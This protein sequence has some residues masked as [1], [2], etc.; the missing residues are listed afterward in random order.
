MTAASVAVVTSGI[1]LELDA[2]LP[3]V[4]KALRAAGASAE[5]LIWDDPSV[6]WG[7][8]DLA[9]IRSTWDYSERLADFLSWTERAGR[10]TR[11]LNPAA[12]VRWNSDKHYLAELAARGVPTAPTRFAEPGGEFG[13]E[14]LPTGRGVVVKPA[15]SAGAVDT[16]RYEAGRAGDALRHVRMLTGQGRAAVVQPY[17]RLIEEGERAL[18]FFAGAFSHAIRK[19][20]VLTEPNVID[21]DRTAHPG[22]SAYEPTPEELATARAALAVVPAPGAPLLARVDLALDDDR[23]PVVMELEL[24]EPNLFLAHHPDALGRFA[25][26]VTSLAHHG[27]P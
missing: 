7:R 20:P 5:I 22:V 19:G 18:V 1:G 16:A 6:D 14:D 26:A 3:E 25:A 11:L 4:V 13:P 27:A 23:R 10:A 21:N 24:I 9:V 12:T 2:D 8:Y 15:V 17:L